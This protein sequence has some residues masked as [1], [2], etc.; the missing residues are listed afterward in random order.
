M[1][2]VILSN[3]T[4]WNASWCMAL[5]IKQILPKLKKRGWVAKARRAT[6]EEDYPSLFGGGSNISQVISFLFRN[7]KPG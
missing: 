5:L 1:M 2:L 3:C 6:V 7:N 4:K